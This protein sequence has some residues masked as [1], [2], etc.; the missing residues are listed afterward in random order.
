MIPANVLA[1]LANHL[2]QSTLFAAAVSLLTLTLRKNHAQARHWLWLTASAKFLIPFPLLVAIG[3]QLGWRAAPV[4][5]RAGITSVVQEISQPF[6]PPQP[7]VVFRTHS[8][9]TF[10]IVSAAILGA[11]FC[12][13]AAVLLSW[14]ISWRRITA[15]VRQAVPLVEGRERNALRRLQRI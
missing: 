9:P 7:H 11:W 2:W 8:R 15:T 14:L 1:A 13:F 4:L 10:P 5:P 6:S 12:G 3:P